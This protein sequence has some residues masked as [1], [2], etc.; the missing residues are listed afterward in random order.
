MQV[1]T[2]K[3]FKI[4]AFMKWNQ[5]NDWC[6]HFD[7]DCFDPCSDQ[8]SILYDYQESERHIK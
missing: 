8:L 5:I 2:K 7:I 3:R 6:L 1:Q 4:S